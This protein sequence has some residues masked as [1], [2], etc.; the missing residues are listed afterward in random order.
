MRKLFILILGFILVFGFFAQVGFCEDEDPCEGVTCPSDCDTTCSGKGIY[1]SSDCGPHCSGSQSA[2]SPPSSIE[3][4]Y[5]YSGS[6]HNKIFTTDSNHKYWKPEITW[7]PQGWCDSD[8][9]TS[10]CCSWS[11]HCHCEWSDKPW[12]PWY[13]KRCNNCGDGRTCDSKRCKGWCIDHTPVYDNDLA[14]C[15]IGSSSVP[16][17]KYTIENM[18]QSGGCDCRYLKIKKY[19]E[20]DSSQIDDSHPCSS[21][22]CAPDFVG[23]RNYCCDS[24]QCAHRG[25]FDRTYDSYD[26]KGTGT[27]ADVYCFDSESVIQHQ[28]YKLK[29]NDGNWEFI[30]GEKAD[31]TD[32]CGK[33]IFNYPLFFNSPDNNFYPDG[34]GYKDSYAIYPVSFEG[35]KDIVAYTTPADDF[36]E[37]KIDGETG[38]GDEQVLKGKASSP[39]TINFSGNKNGNPFN[40]SVNCYTPDRYNCDS[41]H[42]DCWPG[43]YCSQDNPTNNFVSDDDIAK[44]KLGVKILNNNSDVKCWINGEKILDM[45]NFLGGPV[46]SDEIALEDYNLIACKVEAKEANSG[47][48]AKL[49]QTKTGGS[50]FDFG[51]IDGGIE[52]APDCSK[53][54]FAT[55][56]FY[57]YNQF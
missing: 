34:Y 20:C 4:Y 35:T 3:T 25:E 46:R 50:Y 43:S 38:S 36:V 49:Y 26:S 24:E 47:F 22:N 30:G 13:A 10:K 31:F 28:G 37:I 56:K 23:G 41:S 18:D 8:T 1:C 45:S 51:D 53:T 12:Y 39:Q 57:R 29:C 32:N 2:V 33:T 44:V 17:S 6:Q 14:G 40:L 27:Q 5:Y 19:Y 54:K 16:H 9:C 15:N 42:D 21:G 52:T 55:E 11:C 48:D 7:H